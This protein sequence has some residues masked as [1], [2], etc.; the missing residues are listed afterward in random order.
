MS[1]HFAAEYGKRIQ[2]FVYDSKQLTKI[3]ESAFYGC[4]GL[5]EIHC[6]VEHPGEVV[7]GCYLNSF[8][9]I[10]KSQVT[11]YVP[12][13]TVNEYRHL[14]QFQDFKAIVIEK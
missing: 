4:T 5:Q 12:T 6:R 8:H 14:P 7:W 3:G 11:L 1:E 2:S 10:D 13:G 9:D